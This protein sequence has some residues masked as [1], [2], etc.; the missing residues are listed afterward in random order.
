M[1]EKFKTLQGLVPEARICI[2]NGQMPEAQLEKVMM[3]FINKEYDV[4]LCSTII[5]SGLDIPNANTIIVENGD[6]LGLA[7]LYQIR[8][9]V[10]RSDARAYAY[11]TYP[12]ENS[13]GDDARKRLDTIRE[14]T[15]F[16]SGFKVA[17]RDLEIRGAGSMLGERQHG[18]V[19]SI[20]YDLYTRMLNDMI[21]EATGG[22]VVEKVTVNVDFEV[23]SYIPGGYISDPDTRM[24][25][26]RKIAAVETS[27]DEEN[28]IDELLDRFPGDVPDNLMCLVTLSRIKYMAGLCGIS[29]VT[30]RKE[31]VEFDVQ[32][33]HTLDVKIK[34]NMAELNSKYRKQFNIMAGEKRIFAE[35]KLSSHGIIYNHLKL[36]LEVKEFLK[37]LS[38]EK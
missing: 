13:L 2:A 22:K 19:S 36:L 23:S 7:Q 34:E 31:T 32:S 38:G 4:L 10:G 24:E 17:M 26:Y 25:L 5:E 15:E 14:F 37:T 6:R 30:Q 16:G 8:G 1:E 29:A 18:E 20:G 11:I 35:F 27:E 21:T 12:S 9:R 33:A 3:D 28:L